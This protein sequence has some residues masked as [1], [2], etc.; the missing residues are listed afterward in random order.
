MAKDSITEGNIP[1]CPCVVCLEHFLQRDSFH[2]TACYHYFHNRCLYKYLLHAQAQLE[3]EEKEASERRH[4]DIGSSDK[5]LADICVLISWL[6]NVIT[7]DWLFESHN[8]RMLIGCYSTIIT[9]C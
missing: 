4:L 2:R 3:V 8:N 5:V 9:V 1:H 7:A 6:N